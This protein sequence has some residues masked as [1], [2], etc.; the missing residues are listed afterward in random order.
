ME[1]IEHTWFLTPYKK[2][3]MASKAIKQLHGMALPF[4]L[5]HASSFLSTNYTLIDR[6]PQ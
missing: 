3:T 2:L 1:I 5:V 6:W 4:E